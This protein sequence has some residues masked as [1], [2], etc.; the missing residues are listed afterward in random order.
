MKA[1]L[2]IV[3]FALA[4]LVA[5]NNGAQHTDEDNHE[6]H[7]EHE[8]H[9][10]EG[11]VIL[12]EKQQ[13][14]LHLTVGPV[15]IRNLTT[16]VK[17][18]GQLEVAPAKKADVT[19]IVGGNVKE[20][21]VF[22]GDK[23]KKGQVLAVLE[24]PDFIKLQEDFSVIANNLE[25]LEQEYNRQ[26]E[27]FENNV[28]SGK[29][30]QKAKTEYNIS[31]AKY[32]G[33][34]SRLQLLNLSPEAV[35]NGQISSTIDIISP[36]TGYVN[37]VNIKLGTY[38]N[39][40]NIMFEITDNSAIHADFMVYEKDVHLLQLGQKIHFT[41]ANRISDEF[42]A[43]I[44]AIGKKFDPDSRSII[45]HAKIDNKVPGLIPGMYISGHLHTDKKYTKALP[46]DAIVKKGAKSYVFIVENEEHEEH[47]EHGTHE[48]HFKMEEVITGKKDEGY[49]EVSFVDDLPENTQVVLNAAYYLL[50]DMGKEETE[51][52]H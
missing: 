12:S 10:E 42:T 25:F 49:T 29:D 36:I 32:Q 6:G 24:H 44:F 18:N 33:L 43:T 4:A 22:A 3:L 31:K 48:T 35:K 23:I 7:A 38:V 51:H 15:L 8:G 46:N 2:L 13:E 52:S 37:D 41:I 16:V 19:A 5:C 50:A 47:A 26:K 14:A 45:I 27:L 34:K 40:E 1:H 17:V 30:F 9:G 20:I 39:A 28:G 11:V 21:D